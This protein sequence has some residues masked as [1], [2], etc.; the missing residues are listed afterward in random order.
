LTLSFIDIYEKKEV[1]YEIILILS[2]RMRCIVW[3]LNIPL[4]W[5]DIVWYGSMGAAGFLNINIYD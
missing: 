1:A 2:Y 5:V 4:F 3:E